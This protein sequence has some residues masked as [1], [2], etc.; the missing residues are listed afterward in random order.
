MKT[1]ILLT[2]VA[3][4]TSQITYSQQKN[5][6]NSWTE[7]INQQQVTITHKTIDCGLN[8]NG[9]HNEFVILQITNNTA[10]NINVN[11]NALTQYSAAKKITLPSTENLKTINLQANET[12]AGGCEQNWN[13]QLRIFLQSKAPIGPK[14]KLIDFELDNLTINIL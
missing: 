4:L 5:F 2:F 8:S 11:W 9:I 1:G 13:D 12:A 6:P 14:Q 10:A 3:F 7:L